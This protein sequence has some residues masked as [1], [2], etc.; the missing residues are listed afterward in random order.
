ML[1]HIEHPFD[2]EPITV[3]G[4]K[5][6]RQTDTGPDEEMWSAND[7]ELTVERGPTVING[8][9]LWIVWGHSAG[10]Y[11]DPPED[12]EIACGDAPT[13]HEAMATGAATLQ[14]MVAEQRAAEEAMERDYM[15]EKQEQQEEPG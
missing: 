12:Y 6:H 10:T 5:W 14:R 4:L 2:P 1:R 3:G 9:W 15:R 13:R 7:G 11:Y 8:P